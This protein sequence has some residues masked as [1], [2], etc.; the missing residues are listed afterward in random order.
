MNNTYVLCF[1]VVE[2]NVSTR[3]WDIVI[4][5]LMWWEIMVLG[6]GDGIVGSVVLSK[7]KNA[8]IICLF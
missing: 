4:V 5:R 6:V 8:S 2:I 1:P 7:K 3:D